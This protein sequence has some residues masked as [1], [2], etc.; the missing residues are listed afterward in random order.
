MG[1]VEATRGG[2]N[3]APPPGAGAGLVDYLAR[4]EPAT[5]QVVARIPLGQNPISVAVGEGSVWVLD[6]DG[7]VRRIDPVTNKVTVIKGVAQDPRGIAVGQGAVWVADGTEDVVRKID[8]ASDRA[9]A[10][11]PTQGPARNVSIGDDAVWAVTG[12]SILRIDPSSGKASEVGGLLLPPSAPP[13]LLTDRSAI[14]AAGGIV[15]ATISAYPK[16]GRYGVATSDFRLADLD[17]LP[18]AM[19]ATESDVWLAMCGTPGSVVRLDPQTAKPE[20]TISAGGAVCPY[21]TPGDPLAIAVDSNG[22]WVTDAVNGA[23]SRIDQTTNQVDSPIRVG[24]TPTAIA[25]GLGSVWVT[26]NGKASPSPST[27]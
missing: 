18:L 23:I 10:S 3:G 2:S 22:V 20:A 4:V 21:R 14:S 26:V 5:R 16:L 17:V 19:V 1:L 25:V 11:I 27:S 24:D 8:P 9:T 15:W 12:T 7:S 13:P 6:K